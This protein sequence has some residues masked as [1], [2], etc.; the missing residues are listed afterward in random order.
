MPYQQMAFGATGD[1]MKLQEDT[2]SAMELLQDYR[3]EISLTLQLGRALTGMLMSANLPPDMQRGVI[4][5]RNFIRVLQ[6]ARMEMQLLQSSL[7][8]VGWALLAVTLVGGAAT[9]FSQTAEVGM[10]TH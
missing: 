3:K 1:L 2:R 8:P 5:I 7:G 10:D 9:T 6:L 4:V